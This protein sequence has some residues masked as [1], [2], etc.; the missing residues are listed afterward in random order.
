MRRFSVSVDAAPPELRA[1]LQEII[2]NRPGRFVAGR[3]AKTLRFQRD[4]SLPVGLAVAK[5]REF[6]VRYGRRIDAFRALGR[7]LGEESKASG[8]FNETPRFDMS[9]VMIDVS[10]NGVVRPDALRGAN[11]RRFS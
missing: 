6:V 2:E 10:R 5:G 7:L 9:G 8:D 3:G 11:A 1:G 4:T